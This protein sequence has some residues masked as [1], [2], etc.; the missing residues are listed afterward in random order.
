MKKVAAFH[1]STREKDILDRAVTGLT[2][3]QIGKDLE[4]STST[5]STHWRRL[6][7][8]FELANRASIVAKYGA[9]RNQIPDHTLPWIPVRRSVIKVSKE[10]CNRSVNVVDHGVLEKHIYWSIHP[11]DRY[12]FEGSVDEMISKDFD[13]CQISYRLIADNKIYRTFSTLHLTKDQFSDENILILYSLDFFE[14]ELDQN[15]TIV[16]VFSLNRSNGQLE[17]YR[18]NFLRTDLFPALELPPN[19][20]IRLLDREGRKELLKNCR[21]NGD[22]K[23]IVVSM[24]WSVTYDRKTDKR[25]FDVC[26]KIDNGKRKIVSIVVYD[27]HSTPPYD[28]AVVQAISNKFSADF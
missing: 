18:P 3:K 27:D 2:D 8:K 26:L 4:I 14:S 5:I 19:E 20:L 10:S 1:L 23:W 12:M 22:S 9:F 7:I 15:R 6:R 25:S 21:A 11:Q 17:Y 28:R 16:G 13:K 24:E